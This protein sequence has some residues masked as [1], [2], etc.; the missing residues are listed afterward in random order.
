MTEHIEHKESHEHKAEHHTKIKKKYIWQTLSAILGLLLILSIFTAGFRGGWMLKGSL[1]ADKAA[2]KAINFIN[3]NVLSTGQK[4]TLK[5]VEDNGQLYKMKITVSNVEYDSYITKDG[6]LL[7]PSVID[8]EQEIEPLEQPEP[9]ADI[10]KKEKTEVDLFVMSYCPYGMQA[11][12]AMVP[13]MKLLG[14]KADINVRFVSY[15]MHGKQEIDEN[16]V[17]Y[18]I[19]KEESG[20]YVKYLEC[21]LDSKDSDVCI[22]E[23]GINKEKIDSCIGKADEEFDIEANF[24]NKESWLNGRY[25]LYEV[26]KE[27]NE[28]YDVRG[29]PTLIINGITYNGARTEEAY[30]QAICAGFENPPEECEEALSDVTATATGSCS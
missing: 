28:E 8:M 26:D 6:K 10:P 9:S 25:P 13:V 4:A 19:Q 21:F 17:Q 5:S 12:K 14:N 30:K 7:F 23:A 11:Q 27:L 20:K 2:D 24:D 15:I 16:T 1:S 18:C 29:S 22:K 3:T